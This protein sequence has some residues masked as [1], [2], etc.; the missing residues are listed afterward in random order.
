M[1][2]SRPRPGG[3]GRDSNDPRMSAPPL[4]NTYLENQSSL[5]PRVSP[6][7][8]GYEIAKGEHCDATTDSPVRPA[9]PCHHRRLNHVGMRSKDDI[10]SSSQQALHKLDLAFH[11][12][13]AELHA[14]MEGDDDQVCFLPQ[15]LDIAEDPLNPHAVDCPALGGR[16]PNTVGAIGIRQDPDIDPLHRNHKSPVSF[17]D[18]SRRAG[19]LDSVSIEDIKRTLES[20]QPMVHAM[21]VRGGQ[22]V[23]AGSSKRW[24][25]FVRAAEPRKPIPWVAR[26]MWRTTAG[27]S[28]LKVADDQV[29]FREYGSD[30]PEYLVK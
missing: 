10:C 16:R 23:K 2:G 22:D 21:V 30:I 26:L 9:H 28:S 5:S 4:L 14:E 25:E 8:P 17:P 12:L 20:L 13:P 1:G 6:H 11:W 27:E 3:D 18:R 7:S 15:P 24:N 19:V 29:A